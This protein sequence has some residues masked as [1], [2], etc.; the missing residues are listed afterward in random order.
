MY[1]FIFLYLVLG[2]WLLQLIDKLYNQRVWKENT[3][4]KENKLDCIKLNQFET[5]FFDVMNIE[6][7]I[8]FFMYAANVKKWTKQV[9][10][11]EK[12]LEKLKKEEAKQMK[13]KYHHKYYLGQKNTIWDIL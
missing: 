11:D 4:E 13:V 1:N 10:N 5:N 8:I 3:S 7:I 2:V 12:E 9:S 6:I